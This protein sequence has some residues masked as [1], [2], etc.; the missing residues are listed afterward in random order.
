[1]VDANAIVRGILSTID[2]VKVTYYHPDE[3][4]ELPIISY[5]EII[6]TTGARWDNE[7]QAQVSNMQIDIWTHGGGSASR[8]A[9]EV[10]NAMQADGWYRELSRDMPPEDKIYHKT[11][12]YSKNIFFN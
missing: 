3:F 12:R 9:I 7:E 10:D 8:L 6:T 5:F 4:N 11:M 1:M 2:G